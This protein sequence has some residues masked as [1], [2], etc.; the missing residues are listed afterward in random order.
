MKR[1]NLVRI[2]IGLLIIS[3]LVFGVIAVSGIDHPWDG[4][5]SPRDKLNPNDNDFINIGDPWDGT[6][7]P[8][9][10]EHPWDGTCYF[11]VS[12]TDPGNK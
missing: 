1:K 4:T 10:K 11:D 2:G 12:I 5:R 8:R 9:D 7:S 3:I 6:K